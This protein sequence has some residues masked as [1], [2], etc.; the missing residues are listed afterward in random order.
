M[1]PIDILFKQI[2]HDIRYIP[3]NIDNTNEYDVFAFRILQHVLQL[4]RKLIIE[5]IL[6][7]EI[8]Q[9]LE[10]AILNDILEIRKLYPTELNKF[11]FFSNYIADLVDEYQLRC[12]E[13]ELY[14]IAANF[15]NIKQV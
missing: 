9:I 14:E 1:K 7:K 6:N 12:E 3:D 15:R 13:L 8:L 5:E 11:I 4:Y 2:D 10:D